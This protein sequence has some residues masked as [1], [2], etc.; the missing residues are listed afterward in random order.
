M[1]L[2]NDSSDEDDDDSL[3]DAISIVHG[4]TPA[5]S[6]KKKGQAYIAVV[7]CLAS[8]CERQGMRQIVCMMGQLTKV[9][10]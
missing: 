10:N 7:L 3:G 6:S 5:G 9:A 4:I 8:F 2:Q 1:S